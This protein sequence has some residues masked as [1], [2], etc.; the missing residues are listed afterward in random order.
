MNIRTIF[1]ALFFTFTQ[2]SVVAENIES[3]T[4]ELTDK[5]IRA[6]KS[7]ND[8]QLSQEIKHLYKT[9]RVKVATLTDNQGQMYLG[10]RV[11]RAELLPYLTQLKDMLKDDFQS[12]RANQATRDH[13]SFHMTILSPKEYQLAD[14]ALVEKLLAPNFNSNFSSQLN[15]AL[16]GLGNVEKDN[17]NTYFIIAHSNDAQ[18]IRQRFLLKAKDF[19]VTLGFNPNDIYGVKKDKTT[20]IELKTKP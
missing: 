9:V 3:E 2:V 20:L 15:V 12:Y 4:T 19:H 18:L 8:P 1:L 6:L 5:Q 11:N 10:A 7:L 16:L 13:Q 17:K 14:K